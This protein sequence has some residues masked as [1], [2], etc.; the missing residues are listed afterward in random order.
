M[1]WIA[2]LLAFLSFSCISCGVDYSEKIDYLERQIEYQQEVI[3]IQQEEIEIQQEEIEI[4]QEE[5]EYCIAIIAANGWVGCNNDT[6]LMEMIR[7]VANGTLTRAKWES[8]L[9]GMYHFNVI[10]ADYEQYLKQAYD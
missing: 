6:I 7:Q 8:L 2:M 1:K 9:A 3:E 5:I 10:E 4:Q